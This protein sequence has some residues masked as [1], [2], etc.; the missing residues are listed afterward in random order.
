[1]VADVSARWEESTRQLHFGLLYCYGVPS[2]A[3]EYEVLVVK[4]RATETNKRS[5]SR[6]AEIVHL[7]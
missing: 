7:N 1:M 5:L 4:F 6:I 2:F 3:C